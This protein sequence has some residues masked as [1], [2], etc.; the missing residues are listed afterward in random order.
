MSLTMCLSHRSYSGGSLTVAVSAA[1][2][3]ADDT[4]QH[5]IAGSG[6]WPATPNVVNTTQPI[7]GVT[8]ILWVTFPRMLRNLGSMY[9]EAHHRGLPPFVATA[10]AITVS[11]SLRRAIAVTLK[12][13][14]AEARKP[15]NETGDLAAGLVPAGQLAAY[16]PRSPWPSRDGLP[17]RSSAWQP[18]D[19]RA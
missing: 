13:A 4:T 11:A 5:L 18:A 17:W 12:R 19:P 10:L 14:N 7:S 15:V 6:N 9:G 3:G 8:I 16:G 2:T 1:T